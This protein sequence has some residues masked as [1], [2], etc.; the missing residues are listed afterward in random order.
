M[1][2]R[3]L[4][5]HLPEGRACTLHFRARPGAVGVQG[6]FDPGSTI[7]CVDA[8]LEAGIPV[9]NKVEIALLPS[10]VRSD[11]KAALKATQLV[12]DFAQGLMFM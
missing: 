8:Y 2:V 4:A 3:I 12:P 7:V 1:H 11:L 9:S 5:E 10:P 6:P